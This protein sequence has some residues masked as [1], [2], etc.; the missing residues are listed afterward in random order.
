MPKIG[1]G[2]TNTVA[3]WNGVYRRKEYTSKGEVHMARYRKAAKYR[4][5][6]TILDVGCGEAGMLYAIL[7]I[8]STTPNIKYYGLDYSF[9]A[10]GISEGWGSFLLADWWHLP[11]VSQFDTVYLNEALEHVPNPGELLDV[12]W[13]FV[14]QRL[15]ITVPHYRALTWEEHRGE[16][17]WDFTDREMCILLAAYGQPQGPIEANRICNLWWVDR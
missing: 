4:L 2:A 5:G 6:T 12:I 10:F 17:A 1:D 8:P 13:P 16:H 14:G 9:Q 3:Y 7:Q 15:V 11:F